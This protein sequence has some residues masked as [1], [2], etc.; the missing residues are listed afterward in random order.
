MSV[1]FTDQRISL[2]ERKSRKAISCEERKVTDEHGFG[3]I[4]VLYGDAAYEIFS[5][6]MCV[7]IG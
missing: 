3:G 2:I 6:L 5:Q 7:S 1:L 4:R